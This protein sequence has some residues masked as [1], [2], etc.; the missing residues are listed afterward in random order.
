MCILYHPCNVFS[1]KFETFSR[2]KFGSGPIPIKH[3]QHSVQDEVETWFIAVKFLSLYVKQLST[4]IF[5][6]IILFKLQFVII[7]R[8]RIFKFLRFYTLLEEC[9]VVI[10][11]AVFQ[12]RAFICCVNMKSWEFLMYLVQNT[13]KLFGS[14]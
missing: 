3:F 7:M 8:D 2:N 13:N 6:K 10:Q 5:R 14:H 11:T 12:I 4:N 1:I 9:S